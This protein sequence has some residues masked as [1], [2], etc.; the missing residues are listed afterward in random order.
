[1]RGG[2]ASGIGAGAYLERVFTLK[3][4]LGATDYDTTQTGFGIG[5]RY[6]YNFGGSPTSPSLKFL[7]GWNH[8]TFN[9]DH[10]ATDIDLPNVSYSSRDLGLGGR[11]PL[12]VPWLSLFAEARWL[13]VL[14]AGEIS[15]QA[16]YG[17]GSKKGL[18]IDGG[19]EARVAEAWSIRAGVHYRRITFDFDGS[20]LRANN[21]D[22]NPATQAVGRT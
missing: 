19:V 22:N 9:I 6:R 3:S 14:S 21:R 15:D 18:D 5:L 10:G 7:F 12:T 16:W 13:F 8:L 11:V 17:G 1:D 4:S 20:G 2:L